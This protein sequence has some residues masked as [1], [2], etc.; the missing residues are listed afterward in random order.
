MLLHGVAGRVSTQ[1]FMQMLLCRCCGDAMEARRCC[2]PR[3]RETPK[4]SESGRSSG[5][6]PG[7]AGAVG[8]ELPPA[9]VLGHFECH[10]DVLKP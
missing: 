8:T 2:L 5:R 10:T 7:G 9:K 4:L 6:N 1:S 3:F